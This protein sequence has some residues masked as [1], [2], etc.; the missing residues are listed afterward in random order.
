MATWELSPSTVT[1]DARVWKYLSMK[2]TWTRYKKIRLGFSHAYLVS[3]GRRYILVDTGNANHDIA[4]L[5]HLKR[6]RLSPD[7]IGLIVITHA[8]F[9]H[10]GGLKAIKAFCQCPVAIHEKEEELVRKG[11]IVLPPG[12]SFFGKAASYVGHNFMRP[13][14]TFS[15]VEPDIIISEDYALSSLGLPGRIIPT[16]GHTEGSL[17]VLMPTG[18]AFVGDLATNYLPFGLGPILPP[19]ADNVPEL[20]ASWEKILSCGATRICPT[21]GKPFPA[22][23]LRRRLQK[24][25]MIR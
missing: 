19:F 17:S 21:H 12:T 5:R 13:L 23:V 10:V 8:H 14:L 3:A 2:S 18:E 1:T 11:R 7:Q 15:P 22:E 4:F 25:R 16:Q 9:D 6:C 24:E 20:L